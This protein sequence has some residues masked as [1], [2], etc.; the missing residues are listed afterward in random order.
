MFQIAIAAHSSNPSEEMARKAEKFVSAI[1]RNDVIILLGGYWGL[2]KV[3]AD[4]ALSEGIPVVMVLPMER[5]VPVPEK[6]VR[7]DSGSE[8]RSRSIPL[9]RSSDVVVA[10]GGGAGTII[11]ILLGYAMGK[12]TFVLKGNGM[13]SDNLEKA[14]P[15]FIDERK[16]TK[17]MY[18]DNV[19]E[20][21]KEVLSSMDHRKVEERFG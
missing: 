20:M 13:S 4:R 5:D 16:V 9:I 10:L 7:I 3:V 21:A 6:V 12:H 2:M 1:K 15:D 11:E 14:F 19:E 17:V 18:F 8:Y